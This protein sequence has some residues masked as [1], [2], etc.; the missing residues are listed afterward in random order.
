MPQ[1]FRDTR[2]GFVAFHAFILLTTLLLHACATIQSGGGGDPKPSALSITTTSLPA[3]QTG[4]AYNATLTAT[5][6]TSPYSWSVSSGTLP[7]GLTLD[8]ATGAIAGMPTAASSAHVTFALSDSG[9]PTQQK[10]VSLAFSIS[11]ADSLSIPTTSLPNGQV[12]V[13]YS[14]T[15]AAT[16]GKTPYT[17][18]Q[19]VGTLPAGLQLNA[20]TGAITGTPTVAASNLALTFQAKDSETPAQTK[21]VNLTLTIAPASLVITT[22]SLPSGQV[23]VAYSAT[24]AATGGKTPYTWSQTAGT[25]P[26]GLQLNASSGAITGMPTVSVTNT[27][28][29]FQVKDSASPAQT[30]TVN[31]TLTI[32]PVTLAITTGSLPGGQVGTPYNFT[33][34]A[35][36]GTTPYAWNITSGALPSGLMLTG[37]TI[38]GTPT[39][40][41]T[42]LALTFKVTDSGSPAQSQSKTLSLTIAASAL[43]ITTVSLPNGRLNSPYTASLAATGGTTPYTWTITSGALPANLNLNAATGAITGT[44]T[45]AVTNLPLTFKVTDSG[46]QTKSV[47]LNLTISA[48]ALVINTSSLPNGQVGTA[49]STALTAT[50]GTTPYTW[51]ITSGTLPANLN[52]NAASGAIT[53]TPTVAVTNLAL[54]FKVTDSGSPALT[55]SADLTLTIVPVLAISTSSLPNG[56]LGTAYSTTLN[57]SGGISPYTWTLTSGALPAGL[58]LAAST[59]VISGT[60]TAPANNTALTFQVR[61]S[62]TPAQT[63]TVNLTL[64]IAPATLVITSSSLPSGQQ[65]TAY[66]ATLAA[67]G[68]TTPYNWTIT[69]G[70]LPSGLNLNATTGAITGTPTVTASNLALTFQVKDSGTPQQTKVANLTL[71]ITPATLVIGTTSLPN[72]Q[73]NVA[74]SATLA[75]TGGTTPYTWSQTA[76]T[77]PAGLQLDTSTGAITGTPT[78]SVTSTPLTFQVQDSGTPQQTKTVNLALTIGTGLNISVTISPKRGGLTVG[79]V[80]TNLTATVSNDSQNQ[81]VTWSISPSASGAQF[82]P[83][84]SASGAAVSFT[85]PS[86]PGVYT[87]TAT[88]VTDGSQTA[89]ATFGVTNLGGVFTWHNNANRDGANSQEYALT[90]AL[91]NTSTFGRLFTCSIDA[92]AYAQ[93]LWVANVNINGGTHNVVYVVTQHD[94]I[95]A[96]DADAQP[97]VTLKTISLLGTNETWLSNGDVG[98]GDITPAIGIVGTPVVDPSTSTIYLVAKSKATSGT[99]YIQR[100]HAL[101]LNDLSERANSP[102]TIATGGS[103]SFALI[104]NQRPGLALSGSNVYVTWAS[105][106]DNGPYHGFVYAFNK[107]SLAQGAT[108]NV[109]PSGTMAGIWMSGAAP[110]IDASGNL[111]CITGNGTFDATNSDFGDSFLKLS[112]GLSLVDYFTPSDEQNDENTDTDFGSGGAAILINATGGSVP[113]LAVGGGKDGTLYILNRDNMGHFGDPNAVQTISVGHGIF[114]TSAFWQNTLYIAPAGAAL[115]SYPLTNGTP[116]F[117]ATSSQTGTSFGWPGATPSISSLGANNGIIWAIQNGSPAVLHAYDPTQLTTELWNSSQSGSDGAGTYVKF[118]VPTVAN[119]KVYVGTASQLTVFGLKPD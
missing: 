32:V 83:S 18:S 70:A 28:L 3:G 86:S 62:E 111:F 57:A 1:Q 5:G 77:L 81:G 107:T 26:A 31:L 92:A 59:G 51:T 4:K 104:Q 43:A 106:G 56:Q 84:T 114:S 100:L 37:S 23:G 90:P 117:G 46:S 119:G 116:P 21:T 40:A 73:I 53:G 71:T 16:G 45:V 101:S 80:I 96:F 9:S 89:S 17:W 102:A 8:A 6:G 74:Y 68:G 109:T 67:T 99:N 58:N 50:G 38:S 93:P 76:G 91:V 11:A 69:S 36:G 27:S 7:A 112:S 65:G 113:N 64:T 66:S 29:T 88:S 34:D 60:P 98:T 108:F 35:S 95:Y 22:S 79:Q 75:A 24:L 103:S 105:H 2:T 110:A 118:T 85:A 14:A 72:G 94:T 78:V 87:V 61:D 12:G 48:A 13:A 25:L 115:R 97:C 47:T 19:T 41:V 44:P 10:S 52:L 49:Y 15:L 63:K 33:L 55:Q 30:K 82:N 42:N 39:V 20:T 54:T